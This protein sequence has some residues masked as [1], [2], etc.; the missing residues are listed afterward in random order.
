MG[1]TRR[2]FMTLFGGTAVSAVAF[3]AC[4]IP[5]H[6]MLVQSPLQMPEDLVT[7][8]D[9]WY[10]TLCGQCPSQEGIVVRV[11]EGRAKKVEGNPDYPINQGKHSARCEAGLQALYHPDRIAGPMV[12]YGERGE[13]KWDEIGWVDG[14]TRIAARL[15]DLPHGR[16][17]N[18]VV[19]TNP[20]NAHLG[21]VISRFVEGFGAQHLNYE[22]LERTNL[23]AATRYAFGDEFMPDFD[24]AESEMVLSFGADFLNTWVSPVRYARAYGEFRQG[25]RSRGKL[26]HVDSRLSLTAANADEWVYV[27]PGMEGLL[28]RSIAAALIEEGSADP[29]AAGRITGGDPEG[30]V[31][32][33][34]PESAAA[35]LSQVTAQKIRDIA[36]DFASHQPGIA[37]G[38]GSAGAHTNGYSNLAAVYALNALVGSVGTKGG[39]LRNPAPFVEPPRGAESAS[40][41]RMQELVSD[42]RA[43]KVDAL[44]VRGV[45]PMFGLPES[46]G[47]RDASYNVPLIVSFSEILDDTADMADIVLP[48]NSPLEDW[49]SSVP[50]PGAGMRLVGFQQPV[51][52]PYFEPRGLQLG[53][54]NFGEVLM[55]LAKALDMDLGLEADT[56]KDVLQAD[57]RAMWE[58]GRGSVGTT[59]TSSFTDF[60]AFWNAA[61]MHGFWQEDGGTAGVGSANLDQLP[62]HREP[63]ASGP[64]GSSTFDL[65][66]F[67]SSGLL[68]GR[69]AHLPWLQAMTDTLT[70]AAWQTWAEI[71][72][73]V[74]EEMGIKEGDV[75]RLSSGA[76]EI[77]AL[78]YPHPGVAPNAVC[79]PMGQGHTANGRYAAGRGSNVMDALAPATDED[80]GAL[81]WAATRVRV[82]KTGDW[83]RLPKFE[84]TKPDLAIDEHNDVIK[85]T[86]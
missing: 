57:A 35:R 6:E 77:L 32:R 17:K 9:N 2:Q 80:T 10:A 47:F 18:V 53:T 25:N 12:R 21:H 50:N 7:G 31:S 46:L 43:G 49:G 48:Q 79:V 85:I 15:E 38:G 84:N 81:A 54:K 67:A 23:D 28:A 69:G 82:E 11:V 29:A 55:A 62:E 36:H 14:I 34:S 37:L 30:F 64:Q 75:L 58:T 68:D 1:L 8:L 4:G 74:A 78:A 16:R 65:V 19:L 39:V 20:E 86:S 27:E 41:S 26:V 13:N 59:P 83:V 45:D 61:L 5:A 40:F 42:M 72:H 51:V 3:Q 52:R 44:L 56:F 63:S 66:P 60:R 24:I 70:T 76:G 22:T 33:F 73:N 71:N